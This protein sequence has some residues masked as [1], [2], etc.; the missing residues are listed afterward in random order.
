MV[1]SYVSLLSALSYHGIVPE[2]VVTTTSATT[3]RPECFSTTAGQCIYQ[4]V[5]QELFW[6]YELVK[7]AGGDEAF[8]ATPEKALL[9][10][11]HLQSSPNASRV[12]RGLRLQN[13][14]RLDAAR[15]RDAVKLARSPRVLKV[16]EV[17]DQ[18]MR[19]DAQ[20]YETL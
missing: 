20:E 17:I 19:D 12:R 11:V 9:D 16:G 13:L 5:K 1:P 18:M 2:L 6:G 4:H 15:L 8:M 14:E 7:L 3:A 10:V